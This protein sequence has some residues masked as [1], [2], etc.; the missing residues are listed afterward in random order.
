MGVNIN[1]STLIMS[2]KKEMFFENILELFLKIPFTLPKIVYFIKK[3]KMLLTG[4]GGKWFIYKNK[5]KNISIKR[6]RLSKESQKK[7]DDILKIK[8]LINI[9]IIENSKTL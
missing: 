3:R 9:G 2:V 6:K 4:I 5:S 7:A 8:N 1:H